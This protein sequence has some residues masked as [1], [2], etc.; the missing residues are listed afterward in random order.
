MTTEK[1]NQ[2]P[3]ASTG[4]LIT[5]LGTPEAPTT[6]ALRKYLREFLW[7]RRVV[8]VPRPIWWLILNG[9]ILTTRPQKSAKAYQQVWTEQGSPLLQISLQQKDLLQARLNS[10]SKTPVRLA[11]GMR[12]G[13][14]SIENALQELQAANVQR[15]LV[16][17]LYPQHATATTASTFDAV[18]LAMKK[19]QM[20]PDLR[21]VSSYYDNPQYISALSNQISQ[22]WS[23]NGRPEKLFFSFHGMPEKTRTAGDPYYFQCHKTARLVAEQLKLDDHQWLVAFQSRF[24]NEEWLKPYADE[25]LK[26]LGNE[27]L[28]SIDVICPGFSADCLETL[29]EMGQENKETFQNA[30]GGQYRYIPALNAS[31]EHISTLLNIIESHTTDWPIW[32][33]KDSSGSS[34]KNSSQLISQSA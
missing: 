17:P 6:A 22:F 26:Q 4:I 12:Y 14:P 2:D 31:E 18:G 1:Y 13:T 25:T 27:G 3:Q 10:L 11:L 7:D 20:I 30:G 16:L 23:E 33:N 28:K 21:F 32:N 15:I 8:D 5:N 9:A 34:T 24:G 29:E 19:A